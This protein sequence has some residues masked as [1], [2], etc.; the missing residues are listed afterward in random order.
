MNRM[1]N[2]NAEYVNIPSNE[3]DTRSSLDDAEQLGFLTNKEHLPSS[4]DWRQQLLAQATLANFLVIGLPWVLVILLS[5]ALAVVCRSPT[6]HCQD[7]Q[8]EKY[9]PARD[10]IEY[11][12]VVF[13]RDVGTHHSSSAFT[14]WPN[15][16]LDARWED[17][18]ESGATLHISELENSRLLNKS[19]HTPIPGLEHTYIGGL[20]VFHQLHCLNM[21]RKYFYPARY[22]TS[23][24]N[25][26]GTVN[27]KKWLHMDH[28]IDSIRQSLMCSSDVAMHS[29]SWL[30][31]FKYNQVN[32]GTVHQCRNFDKIREW[33]KERAV[34]LEGYQ[35]HVEDGKI[36]DYAGDGSEPEPMEHG[37][38]SGFVPK[39]WHHTKE[40]MYGV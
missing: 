17:I 12:D 26:D 39:G 13:K 1:H 23:V 29:Y 19:I 38:S 35:K 27:F 34:K 18:A 14:G 24:I 32:F 9:S 2:G 5:G 6:A 8:I 22:N 36:V 4:L 3:Q 30:D 25:P 21:V 10:A 15:D 40:E 20:D 33:A 31:E 7:W 16:E 28:C 11:H 37:H